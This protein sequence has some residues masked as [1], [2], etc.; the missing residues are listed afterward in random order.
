M[1]SRAALSQ[2]LRW[3]GHP[4]QLGALIQGLF[5]VMKAKAAQVG[6]RDIKPRST[7]ALEGSESKSA[8]AC[9]PLRPHSE[10]ASSSA[11]SDGE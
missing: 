2:R 11:F 5:D 7:L 1:P 3:H 4:E 6:P 10:D 9:G 8:Q